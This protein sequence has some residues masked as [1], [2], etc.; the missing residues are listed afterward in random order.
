VLVVDD[1]R[2]IGR[3][4]EAVLSDAGY[5]VAVLDQLDA[6]TVLAAVGWLEP[7]CVLLDSSGAAADYGASWALAERLAARE[8]PVPVVM[9]TAHAA[10][11]REATANESG[12]SQ[13]AHFAGVLS[14]PFD[15]DDLEA[16]VAQAPSG[17][18]PSTARCRR[19]W[20]GRRRW[21]RSLKRVG[22]RTCGLGSSGSG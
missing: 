19:R 18:I 2:D 21:W 14:K 12:R 10:A 3:L 15:L 17:R 11:L 6:E 13:A 16:M 1:D 20:R 5:G 7:D 4:V 22:R 8:R 9:F